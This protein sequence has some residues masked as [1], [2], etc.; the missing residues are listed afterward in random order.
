MKHIDSVTKQN[1]ALV[2]EVAAAN[3]QKSSLESATARFKVANQPARV[4]PQS[5]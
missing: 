3:R 2:E 1:A 4:L 5:A